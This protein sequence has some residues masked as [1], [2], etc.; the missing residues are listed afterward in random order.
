MAALDIAEPQVA[1]RYDEDPEVRW[2]HRVLLRRLEDSRRVVLSPDLEVLVCDVSTLP[3][4]A[5]QRGAD[6][7][8]V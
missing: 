2:H 8:G 6:V 7:P 4:V 3:L 5:L 1:L